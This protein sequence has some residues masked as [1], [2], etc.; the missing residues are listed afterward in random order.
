[1]ASKFSLFALLFLIFF[2]PIYAETAIDKQLQ[3]AQ[4]AYQRGESAQSR[5]ER[6]NAFNEAL[7][8]YLQLE[9][10][11]GNGKLYYNIA[12]SYYQLGEYGLAILY[13]S[14]ALKIMPRHNK[15]SYN[16]AFAMAK[17]GI[18]KPDPK[19]INDTLFFWHRLFSLQERIEHSSLFILILF[20]LVSTY[21]WTKHYLFKAL[22]ITF[23][24]ITLLLLG[25]VL[26]TQYIEPQE[27]VLISAYG[28][29]HGPGERFALAS[30]KPLM[31]GETVVIEG[32]SED[33][34]WLK[35]HT[36]GNETGY[37][38]VDILRL[39]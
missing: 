14:K 10:E 25:S 2:Q 18:Y 1:M 7:K 11:P 9:G 5:D 34:E 28:L 38:P 17:Q 16:R 4:A 37:L 32:A 24:V 15:A 29:Y 6:Q 8:L 3:V 22:S 35:I 12:N 30:K 13:Y 26:T 19:P 20:I 39:F 23:S 27:A 33:G 31:A 21:I 36:S